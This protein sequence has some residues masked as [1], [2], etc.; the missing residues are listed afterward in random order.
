MKSLS[1]KGLHILLTLETESEELLLDSN[2]FLEFIR[3]LVPE[4][5]AEIVGITNHIFDNKSFTSA[6]CLKESHLCIHTWP[7]F[8]QLTFDVFLCNYI[9]DNTEKVERIADL[10]TAY[11]NGVTIHKHKIYR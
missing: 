4:N 10:V 2:S 6:V 1:S 9:Q 3:K 7:E 8:K 5:G 11:F